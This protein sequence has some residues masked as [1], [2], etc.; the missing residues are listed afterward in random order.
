MY[1][2]M[3]FIDICSKN[4]I[5]FR[6]NVTI[7]N[8]FVLTK[9]KNLIY[10]CSMKNFCDEKIF[11][12]VNLSYFGDVLLTNALCQNIKLNY[13]DSKIVFLVN[14]PFVEAASNQECVDDVLAFDKRGEHKGFRGLLKFVL[15]CPYKNKIH[16]SF[17]MYDNDRAN[18]I[19]FL[20]GVKTR[21]SGGFRFSKFF[22]NKKFKHDEKY[23]HMQDINA[24]FI[25]ALTNSEPK[26]LPIKYNT[27]L[28]NDLFASSL[29]AKYK[30]RDI[31]G[32][33]TVSKNIEKDMPIET[34][35]EIINNYQKQGKIVLFLGAGKPS[36]DYA[37]ELI[38]RGCTDF[39]NLVNATTISSL[40]NILTA[41]S[42]LITVDTGTMHL[43]CAVNTPVAV[44]FY[45]TEMIEKWAPREF[46]YKSVIIK[47]GYNAENICKLADN[48]INKK[49]ICIK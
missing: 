29:L 39:E 42:V 36:E 23:M 11:L 43:A 10:I 9:N 35:I 2:Y 8:I 16:T 13:P 4:F 45:K 47:N 37:N 12:V 33:C 40:A 21:I 41:C 24:S 27:N 22:V 34:A 5:V 44:V 25:S 30:G 49:D 19:T 14:K 28:S 31:I 18:L 15:N 20:L 6:V 26:I 32:L 38:R 3:L 7:L 46:L 48:L 1:S 17:V